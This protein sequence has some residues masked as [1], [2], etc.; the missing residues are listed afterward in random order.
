MVVNDW[1]VIHIGHRDQGER[2]LAL[3][4]AERNRQQRRSK[5]TTGRAA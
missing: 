1:A 5:T 2:E 3:A 4:I